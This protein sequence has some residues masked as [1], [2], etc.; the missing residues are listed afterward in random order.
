MVPSHPLSVPEEWSPPAGQFQIGGPPQRMERPAQQLA[1]NQ[2]AA[3][4]GHKKAWG[5]STNGGIDGAMVVTTERWCR[6]CLSLYHRKTSQDLRLTEPGVPYS[7]CGSHAPA[8][9]F[10]IQVPKFQKFHFPSLQPRFF[11]NLSIFCA[12]GV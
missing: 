12:P 9:Q 5:N 6:R 10:H 7:N 1:K 4:F 2:P 11:T 8:H 3:F